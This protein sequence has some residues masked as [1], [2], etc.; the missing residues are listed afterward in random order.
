MGDRQADD[1]SRRYARRGVARCVLEAEANGDEEYFETHDVAAEFRA[2]VPRKRL[3][4]WASEGNP[5]TST[6]VM[7]F[8]TARP[9]VMSNADRRRVGIPEDKD[10]SA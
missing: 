9:K 4:R 8:G 7:V 5:T 6:G 3:Q 2:T 10:L 1:D